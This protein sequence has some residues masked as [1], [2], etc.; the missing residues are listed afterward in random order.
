MNNKKELLHANDTLATISKIV[1][2][3]MCL[4]IVQS[5]WAPTTKLII[6]E[7]TLRPALEQVQSRRF[8]GLLIPAKGLIKGRLLPT[9]H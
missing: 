4:V 8:D 1:L 7:G 3:F 5:V 2:N 6:I 9:G